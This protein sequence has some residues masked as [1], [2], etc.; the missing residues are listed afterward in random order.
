LAKRVV[1]AD[2]QPLLAR[3]LESVLAE[4]HDFTVVAT[5]TP[6]AE[7]LTTLTSI[8]ADL[9][10]LDLALAEQAPTL[11]ETLRLLY[12]ELKIVMVGPPADRSGIRSAFAKGAEGYL[13]RTIGADELVLG[14]R[15][16]VE[17]TKFVALGE[18]RD[19]STSTAPLTPR[20]LVILEAVG[21][22]LSNKDIAKDLWV[23]EQTVKFHLANTYRKLG[24]SNRTAAA[25]AGRKLNLL[26]TSRP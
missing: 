23:T 17:A 6:P 5:I 3:G 12:L 19:W 22:G 20:E 16:I 18:T 4:S 9:L 14:L 11:I 8:E 2:S 15:Q 25:N 7:I 1:V 10:L 13:V 24:V 21:N 26:T